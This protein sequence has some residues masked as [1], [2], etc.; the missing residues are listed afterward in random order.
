MHGL[1]AGLGIPGV[2]AH[3]HVA[4]GRRAVVADGGRHLGGGAGRQVGV[5]SFDPQVGQRAPAVTS[6][7]ASLLVSLHSRSA[8]SSSTVTVI[9]SGSTPGELFAAS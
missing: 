2:V 5:P 8:L 9:L 6:L 7:G 3:Q 1:A 4:G